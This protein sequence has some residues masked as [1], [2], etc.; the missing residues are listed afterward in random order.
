MQ[1]NLAK[2]KTH[3]E[4]L[5]SVIDVPGR[6]IPTF[7]DASECHPN[8]EVNEQ[9]ILT[10]EICERGKVSRVDYAFDPD[11]LLFLIFYDITFE[12]ART[13]A[14]ANQ[15]TE[16]DSRR[17]LFQRQLELLGKLKLAWQQNAKENQDSIVIQFP[18]ND[19][20]GRR[21]KYLKTLMASGFLY[22][23]ALE[24]ANKKYP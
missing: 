19:Y 2:I 7:G 5:A 8:I 3:V 9:G 17:I 12:M 14:A 23:E 18:F 21:Q 4:K 20:E 15:Q 10:Y 6:L 13:F 16:V 24:K 22:K 1:N 11:H